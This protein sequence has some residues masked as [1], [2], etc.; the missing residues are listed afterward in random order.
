MWIITAWEHLIGSDCEGFKKCCISSAMDGP[1]GDMQW[2]DSEENGDVRSECGGDEG[3]VKMES[4]TNWY[5]QV[6]SDMLCVLRV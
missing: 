6:E 4:D 3:T 2:D 5:M 1:D